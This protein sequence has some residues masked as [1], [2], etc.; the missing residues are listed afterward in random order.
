MIKPDS[1]ARTLEELGLAIKEME[2]IRESFRLAK[3]E[4][5]RA[6]EL[7]DLLLLRERS[8]SHHQVRVRDQDRLVKSL[9]IR[10]RA[11]QPGMEEA[12]EAALAAG[13]LCAEILAHLVATPN[14]LLRVYHGG[15]IER[16]RALEIEDGS[17]PEAP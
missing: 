12:E 14:R 15:G 3:E 5:L 8:R 13:A 16:L 11:D 1:N 6:G 2:R 7:D 10:I 4:A 9:A 17:A